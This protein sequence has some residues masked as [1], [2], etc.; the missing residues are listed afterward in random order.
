ML[1]DTQQNKF[2][3]SQHCRFSFIKI[4]H[5]LH[6][7]PHLG[8]ETLKTKSVLPLCTEAGHES[9]IINF[10]ALSYNTACCT[11][12]VMWVISFL[13]MSSHSPIKNT[14]MTTQSHGSLIQPQLY[15]TSHILCMKSTR[16]CFIN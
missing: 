8:M 16:K 6:L 15:G 1:P 13:C 11:F 12:P 9:T 4:Y 5:S 14:C 3:R 7:P 2:C 10:S